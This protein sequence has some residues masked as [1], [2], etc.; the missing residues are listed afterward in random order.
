MT[1]RVIGVA[2]SGDRLNVRRL[3]YQ[4]LIWPA[5]LRD[6]PRRL[7]AP[8]DAENLQRLA[9]ALVDG[10]RRNIELARDFFGRQMLVDEAKA[11]ELPRGQPGD[12]LLGVWIGRQAT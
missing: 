6:E 3:M 10:V 1:D 9:D 4:S 8:I 11:I 2:G 12:P 7:R 5:V